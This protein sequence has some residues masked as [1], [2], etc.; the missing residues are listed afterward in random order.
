MVGGLGWIP[1]GLGRICWNISASRD[2]CTPV[3]YHISRASAAPKLAGFYGFYPGHLAL[4][5]LLALNLS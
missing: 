4:L 3:V 1:S 5:L 2:G